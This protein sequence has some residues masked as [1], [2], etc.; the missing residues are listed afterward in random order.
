MKQDFWKVVSADGK[1]VKY[2]YKELSDGVA[3]VSAKM[4]GTF[5]MILQRSVR[6][7]LTRKQVEAVFEH[8]VR[9][10]HRRAPSPQT[11]IM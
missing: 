1:I 4:N 3:G 7:P 10:D 11:L 8:F 5:L 9:M 2:G 6:S